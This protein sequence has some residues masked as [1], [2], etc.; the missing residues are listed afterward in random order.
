MG[1]KIISLF[2]II[3]GPFTQEDYKFFKHIKKIHKF[4]STMDRQ[5]YLLPKYGEALEPLSKYIRENSDKN[6]DVMSNMTS[7]LS[8]FKQLSGSSPDKMTSIGASV[9][10]SAQLASLL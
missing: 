7:N 6:S 5:K 3:N 4:L 8:V 9:S 10:Q 2:T 1:D